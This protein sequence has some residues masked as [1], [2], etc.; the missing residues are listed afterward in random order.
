MFSI[1]KNL[2]RRCETLGFDIV[3]I[4]LTMN[5]SNGLTLNQNIFTCKFENLYPFQLKNDYLICLLYFLR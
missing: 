5:L 2:T 3:I 4:K 1:S